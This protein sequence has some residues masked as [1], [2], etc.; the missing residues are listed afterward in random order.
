MVY[1]PAETA[2]RK[3]YIREVTGEGG[4]HGQRV[5]GIQ[6]W[7]GGKDGESWCMYFATWILD[8]CFQGDA[9]IPRQG[10][11]EAV[12]QLALANGWTAPTP[13]VDDLVLSINDQGLAHHVGIVS[14]L[15]P[16][17]SI[18]GNTSA[19]GVSSNGDRVAEHAISAA[20]KVFVHFP[21]V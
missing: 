16:L 3:L 8:E 17:S 5:N 13:V 20:G 14:S 21:R 2:R 18:A 1:G 11:C 6:V 9:P 10:S 4:N 7:C 12:H 19:D 15:D